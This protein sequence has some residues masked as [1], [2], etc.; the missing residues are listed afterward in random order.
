[1]ILRL[2]RIE[3]S[4]GGT[5]ILRGMSLEIPESEFFVLMGPTGCGKTTSLRVAGLLD[6]PDSGQ[7]IFGGVRAP[8]GGKELLALRRRMATMFQ[9]PVMFSGTVES[10]ISWGLKIRGVPGGEITRRAGVMMEMTGLAGFADR[11]ALTLSG[12]EIRRVALARAMVIGPEL[13][14]LDEPTTSL[15]PSFRNDL[16]K[17][18]KE[19]HRTTGTTFLM[20]T[21]NFEDALAVGTSGAVMQNGEIEQSGSMES[22]LFS[23]KNPFMAE[24]TGTGNILPAVFNGGTATAGSLV[25]AHAGEKS[26]PGYLTV[27]PEVIVLA[28]T[29]SVT[30][31][32]NH[33]RG[34]V[35]GICRKG[36]SWTVSVDVSGTVL[37]S[38]VTTGA[39]DEL[40]VTEGSDVCISFKASAVHVF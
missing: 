24:F 8:V 30:S 1:M 22:I 21:H 28:K 29:P 40:Q 4:K 20:A 35:A 6:R 12:G 15:H 26:G 2:D 23:P 10:N 16:L 34:T 11:D 5:R 36:K 32:R 7:V 31:E 37:E 17:S 9:N 39:L 3:K 38:T 19:L 27:P 14:I 13:L 25:I 33:F 18:I